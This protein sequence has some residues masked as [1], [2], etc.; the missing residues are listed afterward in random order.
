[1][2]HFIIMLV[3]IVYSDRSTTATNSGFENIEK[4]ADNNNGGP[5]SGN[6]GQTPPPF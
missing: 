6:T 3:S 1:M 2:I 5:I 4:M